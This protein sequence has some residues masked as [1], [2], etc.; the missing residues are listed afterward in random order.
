MKQKI[1]AGLL[2]ICVLIY[3]GCGAGLLEPDDLY[4]PPPENMGRGDL[5]LDEGLALYSMTEEVENATTQETLGRGEDGKY[6][7]RGPVISNSNLNASGFADAMFVYYEAPFDGAFKMRARIRM[8]AYNSKSTSKGYLFGIFTKREGGNF[9]VMSRA[10]GLLYRTNENTAPNA[11]KSAIR[12]YK[13]TSAGNWSAGPNDSSA[14]DYLNW[15]MP[16][17]NSEVI[18]EFTRDETGLLM[19][20]FNSKTGAPEASVLIPD[21]DLHQDTLA[22]GKPVYAGVALL[23]TSLEFSEF[24]IWSSA[25][26]EAGT[27]GD[28]IHTPPTS[29]AYVPVDSVKIQVSRNGGGLTT[30][31]AHAVL[32]NT[33]TYTTAFEGLVSLELSPLFE[34]DW[35]DNTHADWEVVGWT[36]HT[37]NPAA[38][39][40]TLT[41]PA[42]NRVSVQA[43]GK[44]TA[45]IL[46]T[47]RDPGL[48]PDSV[49]ETLADYS[50]ELVIN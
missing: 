45:L 2:G 42:H 30:P 17:W 4:L 24:D 50:L 49:L 33:S 8:T 26:P 32:P 47:S 11:N 10:G 3:A 5:T 15:G 20:T 40:P 13:Y 29:P 22:Y 25:A 35:A 36:P 37:D 18:M 28:V 27:A 41:N 7:I 43:A 46:A 34:P 23:A 6:N 19:T 14:S 1:C 9:D 38:A 44:G 31:P 16:N 12:A 39:A 48:P 21:D